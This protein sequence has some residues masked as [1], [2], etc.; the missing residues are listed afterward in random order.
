MDA[1]ENNAT[2]GAPAAERT[3][4]Q[5]E[6]DAIIGDRLK[7][8][9]SKFADYDELKA[10]ADAYDAAEDER[11]S[12]LEKATER[13][14]KAEQELAALK[15]SNELARTRAEIANEA[16]IP[17][18]LLRGATKEELEA[19]AEAIK[20]AFGSVSKFPNVSD[21]GGSSA[22][23]KMTTSELFAQAINNS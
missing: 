3:F 14:A 20:A 16:G 13:A 21:R 2:Q 6:M 18:E 9:R 22:A 4:T 19:H 15:A 5:S 7:R 17:A 11:K 23:T 10:K 8:E 12:D 1:T